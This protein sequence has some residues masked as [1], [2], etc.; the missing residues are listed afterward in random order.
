M[1]TLLTLL[2]LTFALNSFAIGLFT[3]DDV[4]AVLGADKVIQISRSAAGDIKDHA[5][6][7]L[8]PSKSARAYV[9]EMDKQVFLFA[10]SG[11]LDQLKVCRNL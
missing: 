1:K 10:T 4:Q 5:C 9:V 3:A 8:L 11:Q 7:D 2:S 6:V